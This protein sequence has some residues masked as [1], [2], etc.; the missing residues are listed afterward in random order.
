MKKSNYNKTFKRYSQKLRSNSTNGEIILWTKVLR[1]KQMYDLQFN[2]QFPIDNYIVDFICRK[3]KLIIEIDGY[4]HQFKYDDD[5][6]RD[7]ILFE[8]GYEI[9]RFTEIEVLTDLENVIR[10]IENFVLEKV[11]PPTPFSKGESYIY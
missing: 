4:S 9:M 6:E 1:T 3:I 5:I 10:R 7:K 8:L 2:R 11:N